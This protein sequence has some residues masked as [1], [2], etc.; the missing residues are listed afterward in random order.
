MS[1][2]DRENRLLVAEDWTK[3]YQ[4]FRSADFQSYDFENIRR[5]MINYLRQNYPEDFNDY[6]ES[7]EYLALIDLIAFFGQNIAFRVDLNAR[8]NFLELAE[9]RD[10]VLR[11]ARMISYNAKRNIAAKGLLKFSTVQTTE[12]VIDSNGRNLSNQVITWNDTSNPNWYDQFI[13][14]MNAAM[15]DAQQFGNPS[16]S[17]TIYGI[18]TEQYRFQAANTDVPVY[19]FSKVISGRS[20]NFEITS[21]TFSGQTYI[22]EESPKVGNRLACVYRDD[23]QGAGSANSGFFLNFTQGSLNT[24]TFNISQPSTNEVINIDTQGI[25]N[26]DVW[27][28]SLDL[29]GVEK[30]AWVQVP[31]LTGNNII[32]NSLSKNIKNIYGVTTRA[33]DAIS[34]NFSD[35]TFGNLPQGPFRVYYRISNGLSYV[36]NTQDI[37]NVTISIPYISST[38]QFETLTVSLNLT[39]SVMSSSPSETNESIKTNAPQNYYTQNRMITGEDYNIN[40]LTANHQILKVKSI[41]RTSSGISRYFDVVDPTSKYSS[42]RLFSDDGIIYSEYYSNSVNFSYKTRIDIQ[43]A[44]YNVILPILKDDGLKNYYYSNF[45]SG[46]LNSGKT[47]TWTQNSSDIQSSVGVFSES[48]ASLN[49]T[50]GAKIKFVAPVGSYF[51]TNQSNKLVSGFAITPGSSYYLWADVSS[52]SGNNYSLNTILPSTAI[53]DSVVPEWS[54]IITST[55][56]LTEMVELIL[57]NQPFGLRYDVTTQ[58]W[59]VVLKSNLDVINP[60][61]LYSQGD[62]TNTN[63]DASWLILLTT[64]NNV[65][66]VTSREMRYVFESDKQLRFFYDGSSTIY[67]SQTSNVINDLVTVLSYNTNPVVVST[68]AYAASNSNTIVVN[69]ATGI[70]IGMIVSGIGIADNTIVID[71]STLNG[72][73]TVTLNKVTIAIVSE[74]VNFN[75]IGSSTYNNDL[76][77]KIIGSYVGEDGYVDTKKVLVSFSDKMG[78]DLFKQVVNPIQTDASKYI[79]QSRYSISSGQEDYK[80]ISNSNE[81]VKILPTQPASFTGYTDKQYF[82][83]IDTAV[84]KQYDKTTAK[85]TP[86]LDYK[87]YV[88][89]SDIKY[90]YTHAAKYESRIDPGVS[91]IMDVYILTTDYDISFRQWL[92]GVTSTKPLPPSSD[93]LHTTLAPSLDLIKSVSDEIIYHPVSYTILFGSS[94]PS[95]L[96]ATFKV[97]KNPAQVISD[98]D[99]KTQVISAINRF[100][101]V[102]NWEFGDTFYFT[103]LSAYVI[104]QLAP[105]IVNFVIV[106]NQANMNFGSLFEITSNSDRLFISSAT[107]DNIEIIS[108]ITTSNVKAIN[109]SSTI[110]SN[111]VQQ[112]ITSAPYGSL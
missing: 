15:P 39:T 50:T 10:S 34:L 48:V 107:V 111:S 30:S 4:S 89:R 12:R 26:S 19:S 64:N 92:S 101:A 29:S 49:I 57:L 3:I 74:T 56:V 71:V 38:N 24:G 5:T 65:Y 20:M 2:T 93:E 112:T 42:T 96:Q 95:E 13:K 33:S 23:G 77:F 17:A 68:Y 83:F 62:I 104:N 7:S 76:T 41:N 82:Y 32:Y 108:G 44:I 105:N 102:Q 59:K 67:D 53:I 84:V 43:N 1:A 60:F 16:D 66:T 52:I 98:N 27:L 54:T 36:I 21:T 18:A 70:T 79:V 88:G 35:G 91:N 94:A 22:Y 109:N 51:D 8:E 11:L 86:S 55:D 58:S 47:I 85:L 75:N 6:I 100:F 37:K 72:V 31:S 106:P 103:E 28:Y 97:V 40:P 78:P 63:S 14:I 99:V 90:Q 110:S 9:R 46:V 61:S 73:N 87:V 45:V 81:I 80:Y 25:N 69:N